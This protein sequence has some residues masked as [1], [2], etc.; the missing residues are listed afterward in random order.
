M[1]EQDIPEGCVFDFSVGDMRKKSSGAL[2]YWVYTI[3]TKTTLEKFRQRSCVAVR[4]YSD[5]DWLRKQLIEEFPGCII[6]PIPEKAFSGTLEKITGGSD[7]SDLVEYRSRSMRKFLV[8]AGAHQLTQTSDSLQDFLELSEEEF[9]RR[10]KQPGKKSLED[11]LGIGGRMKDLFSRVDSADAKQWEP[12]CTYISQFQASLEQLRDK[13][14]AVVGRRKQLGAASEA[15]GKAFQAAGKSEE[16]YEKTHLSNAM[17][18]IGKQAEQI[19]LV[20][21]DWSDQDVQ[22]VVE[23]V[24]Y[25]IG[26][27]GTAKENIRRLQKILCARDA[28]EENCRALERKRDATP[29]GEQRSKVENQL[30]S[31]EEDRERIKSRSAALSDTLTGELKRFDVEKAYDMKSVL[32]SFADLQQEYSSKMCLSW[33]TVLPAVEAIPCD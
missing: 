2:S 23:S 29:E 24:T 7:P 30:R 22:Q 12:K 15:F 21:R 13:F 14:S 4:R 5:F 20:Y 32:R 16:Q 19:A 25:Y 6:P 10:L 17:C 28:A 9:A 33:A 8:R 11:E 1:A 27:C 26:L 18:D 3:R 31:A